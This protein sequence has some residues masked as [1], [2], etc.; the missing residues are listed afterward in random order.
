VLSNDVV[1]Y[2]LYV[3][4]VINKAMSMDIGMILIWKTKYWDR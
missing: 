2:L 3:K 4:L 1:N